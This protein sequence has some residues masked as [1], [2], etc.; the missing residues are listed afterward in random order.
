MESQDI[1]NQLASRPRL[2]GSARRRARL[3]GAGSVETPIRDGGRVT[4]R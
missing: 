2:A 1:C 4:A 3:Q